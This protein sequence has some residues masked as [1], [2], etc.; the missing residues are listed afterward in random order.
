MGGPVQHRPIVTLAALYGLGGSIVGSRVAE[1]LGVPF[2][3]RGVAQAVASRTGLPEEV[4]AEVDDEPRAGSGRLASSLCR[5]SLVTGETGG[6]VERL[7]LQERTIRGH[8][9]EFV[10]GCRMTGGV[11]LGRG[12]MVVLRSVPWALHVSLRGSREARVQQAAAMFGID[13]ETAARR[14]RAEDRV[15]REYVRRAYGVDGDDSSLYHLVL[16]STVLSLDVCVDIVVEAAT[17]RVR[18]PDRSP[19]TRGA[20]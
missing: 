7:D 1:R 17:A 2:L 15:R 20:L 3:D 14:Q 12:G 6:S 19:S 9:E 16:D 11:V 8:I 4:V 10:A 5:L 18:D 13:S